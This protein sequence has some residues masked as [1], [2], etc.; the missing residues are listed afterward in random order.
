MVSELAESLTS[1]LGSTA[2]AQSATGAISGQPL[3]STRV[4][5]RYGNYAAE[6]SAINLPGSG[7]AVREHYVSVED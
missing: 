7:V 4:V 1:K 3:S 5:V 2:S 6:I